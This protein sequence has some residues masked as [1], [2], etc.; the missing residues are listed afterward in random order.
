MEFYW[1][2]SVYTHFWA[3]VSIPNGMEFYREIYTMTNSEL[4]FNSQRDGILLTPFCWSRLSTPFQFPTGWNSIKL[5]EWLLFFFVVSIPNGMEFYYAASA[6]LYAFVEVSIPNGM[7]FYLKKGELLILSGMF[8]F[9]TGWNSTIRLGD[10]SYNLQDVSIPNGMEFYRAR[11]AS[12][13]G[14]QSFNSQRDGIL[15]KFL[16]IRSEPY[17]VSIPNGMEFYLLLRLYTLC[18]LCFN[19]QRDGI[20]LKVADRIIVYLDVSIPNGMEFY[21]DHYRVEKEDAMFQFPTGWNSTLKK[22]SCLS[23][24]VCFNSQ[25]DGILPEFLSKVSKSILGFNSQR[26]G[27]LRYDSYQRD[28]RQCVSIPNGMEFYNQAP[29]YTFMFLTRFNSQRDGILH[30]GISAR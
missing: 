13:I 23:W 22:V 24:V 5:C 18:F 9:P 29:K 4:G 12:F 8:Q 11:F 19:S 10:I 3:A 2:I 26:D 1:S 30:Y 17:L 16:W 6:L 20:L 14:K 15:L 25:R 21:E 7:E 28:Q 27:I